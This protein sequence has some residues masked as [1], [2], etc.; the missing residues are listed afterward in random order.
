MS[1]D[2]NAF[3]GYLKQVECMYAQRMASSLFAI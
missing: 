2:D 1:V 3:D